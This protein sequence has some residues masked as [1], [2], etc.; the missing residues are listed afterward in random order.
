[1]AHK[2]TAQRIALLTSTAPLRKTGTFQGVARQRFNMEAALELSM[3]YDLVIVGSLSSDEVFEYIEEHLPPHVK[4]KFKFYNRTFFH[5]YKTDEVFEK[6]DDP[7][8]AG[9]EDI[10]KEN[11]VRFEV[12]RSVIGDDHRHHQMKFAWDNLTNFILDDRVTLVSGNEG[13]ILH[14]KPIALERKRR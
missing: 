1:M 6:T 5:K 12:L 13:N 10:L 8:N 11:N 3:R 4:P 2:V 14:D 7:R 9:W